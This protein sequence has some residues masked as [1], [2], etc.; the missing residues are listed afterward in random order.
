MKR[1]PRRLAYG[2]EATLVEHL[3]ELRSRIVVCLLALVVC[4]GV[5]YAFHGHLLHWL[6]QPLPPEKRHPITLSPAEPFITS[7][8]VALYASFLLAFPIL[9]WQ[10]WAFLAPAFT[11]HTQR[12]VAGF[13]VFATALMAS[14]V[15]FGY[16]VALPGAVH[17]L[18]NYDKSHYQIEI[19]AKDYYSFASVVMLACALVFELPI[20]I[21]GLV[22]LG[23]LT[24]ERLKKNRRLGYAIMAVIA[25]ALPG[26][27][28][29]TTTLEMIPL[30]IL[31]E[32]SIWLS[33]LLDRHWQKQSQDQH[34]IAF[35]EV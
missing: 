32:A 10:M 17:F 30:M 21:L 33:V 31:F 15:M 4:F 16:F 5:T 24:T 29:V 1:L 3:G 26:V 6:N 27:D 11:D 8:T 9:L 19:R 25:V 13:T 28:P 23:V 18:T 22:R 34:E 2:E 35:D 7:V 14:G 12:I 20:I